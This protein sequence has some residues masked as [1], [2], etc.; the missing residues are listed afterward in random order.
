[1]SIVLS[2]ICW[3]Q[4]YLHM[5]AFCTA[6]I[7][8]PDNLQMPSQIDLTISPKESESLGNGVRGFGYSLSVCL[9]HAVKF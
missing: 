3:F 9:I 5:Q 8:A 6:A 2:I 7:Q 4:I 1:M